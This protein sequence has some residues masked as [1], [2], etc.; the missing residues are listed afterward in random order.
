MNFKTLFDEVSVGMIVTTVNGGIFIA[1]QACSKLFGYSEEDFAKMTDKDLVHPDDLLMFTSQQK[2]LLTKQQKS[3]ELQLTCRSKEGK[4]VP[5]IYKAKLIN[6]GSFSG[7]L[8]EFTYAENNDKQSSSQ[9]REDEMIYLD[10][11]MERSSDLIYFKDKQS[12]FIKIS[13]SYKER[14]GEELIGKTDFD[15][16]TND[17]AR[18]AY[19][20][21]KQIIETGI[22]ITNIEEKEISLNNGKVTWVSTSKMPL[23]NRTGNIIG[24]FGISRDITLRKL[25]ETEI[26]EKNDILTAITAHMPVVV[27][28]YSKKDGVVSLYGDPELVKIFEKSKMVKLTI[29]EGLPRIINKT[30]R[31]E[32]SDYLNFPTTNV[33]DNAEHYFD[34]FVFKSKSNIDEYIGLA[35]D[36]T[37]YKRIQQ[38]LKRN[39]KKLEKLN[40]ELNQFSY[41]VSHDLKAPLRAVTNLSEWIEEDLKDFPNEETKS[42]L[43]LMRGR[44][45]RMENLIN[46]ILTYSRV[47][48]A[49]ITYQE[50]D[51]YKVVQEVI[52]SLSVP[53]KFTVTVQEDLPGVLYPVVNLEQIFTNLISNAIKYHDK[54]VGH[55][56]IS[57]KDK[58]E[59]HQFE[60][61]DD[62]PGIAK[63]YHDKIFHIF[64]TLQARD[65]VES[66]GIGLTIVKKIIEERGGTI[67]VESTVDM[68]T[69]FNFT[70]P[71]NIE[72]S[73]LNQNKDKHE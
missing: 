52:E 49:Q 50:V 38:N 65:T 42:N 61:S 33:A 7:C 66:T 70:I 2:S 36:V 26:K 37:T 43:K 22:P 18:L 67:E 48:R 24:T 27:Y 23:R 60:V 54:P 39:A 44:V 28:R 4:P 25:Q 3:L 5:V 16:F 58:G 71:K 63:E 10:S 35:L 69:Q 29:S 12:R 6:D 57:Y 73:V 47:S 41:I 14:Y 13:N 62:G 15:L 19:E 53:P 51:V 46:G 64:Q 45:R 55:I 8:A 9:P 32:D 40:E 30:S 68:G 56:N 17:H 20:D 21:E 31:K 72:K 11:L 59:F 34:N 1:N